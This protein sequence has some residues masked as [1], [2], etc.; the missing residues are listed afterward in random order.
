MKLK[1]K[2]WEQVQ[3]TKKQS[4]SGSDGSLELEIGLWR[5]G[6]VEMYWGQSEVKMD[7]ESGDNETDELTWLV[8]FWQ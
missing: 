1:I 6:Y 2:Q 4:S 3:F 5:K 8:I 7:G